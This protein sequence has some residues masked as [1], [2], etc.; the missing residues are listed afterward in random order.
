MLIFQ[1]TTAISQPIL[2]AANI[3]YHTN[4]SK[5]LRY[6]ESQAIKSRFLTSVDSMVNKYLSYKISY[7]TN[8]SLKENSV[9]PKG[10]YSVLNN[11]L[12]PYLANK[13]SVKANNKLEAP[14]SNIPANAYLFL[15]ILELPIMYV[16]DNQ[17]WD[18][19]FIKQ[20]NEKINNP[21]RSHFIHFRKL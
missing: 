1:L 3:S 17:D 15:D 11:P 2:E 10:I 6:L 21:F 9:A 13:L 7:P 5:T 12:D 14:V 4:A 8:F 20:L 19:V 16:L 18:S